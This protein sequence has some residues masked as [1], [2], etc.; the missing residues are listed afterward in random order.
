[1]E[2]DES[3]FIFKEEEFEDEKFHA[4]TFVTKYRKVSSLES[5][6][7][8][9]VTYSNSLKSQLYLII[10]RDYKDFITITTRVN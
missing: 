2:S 6:K 10:N 4:A 8:Q 7:E 5:L 1:M 9:L 3:H